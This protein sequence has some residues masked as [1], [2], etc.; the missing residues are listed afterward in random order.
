MPRTLLVVDESTTIQEAARLALTG[1][2]WHVVGA[3][4]GAEALELLRSHL[5]D[6]VLCAASLGDEDGYAV[7]RSIRS[8]AEGSS[9]PV[10]LSGAEVDEPAALKAGAAGALAKPFSSEE[11]AD[12]LRATL[13]GGLFDAEPEGVEPPGPV[14]PTHEELGGLG[15][16]FLLSPDAVA[17]PPEG[18][19]DP[20]EQVEVID[21]AEDD[22]FGD[23][24]LLDD[25]EPVAPG[26]ADVG[27]T[28]LAA[29]APESFG[30]L[31][32]G[33]PP[34]E[35]PAA[36]EPVDLDAPLAPATDTGPVEPFGAQE[37]IPLDAA[38]AEPDEG[39]PQTEIEVEP[40]PFP[41]GPTG[42]PAFAGDGWAD[43]PGPPAGPPE[44]APEPATGDAGAF[45][46]P[47]PPAAPDGAPEPE[48]PGEPPA[49]EAGF[50][51]LFEGVV[52]P[53]AGEPAGE[54][55]PEPPSPGAGDE[56]RADSPLAAPA[57]PESEP[58][59]AAPSGTDPFADL[60]AGAGREE[61]DGDRAAPEDAGPAEPP[62]FE[63]DVPAA[64]PAGEPEPPPLD[65]SWAGEAPPPAPDGGAWDEHLPA[66]EPSPAAGATVEQTVRAALERSLSAEALTP[67]VQATVERV[68]WEVVPQL[69]ERLIQEAIERLQ[70]ENP[71][72]A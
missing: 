67:V 51:S 8:T 70:N 43:A 15:D 5:P 50:D 56:L 71:P 54:P 10:I 57:Q 59:D 1:E 39:A 46:E 22:E 41:A 52:S 55:G 29:D 20:G 49:D 11:L 36:P 18:D 21:L 32:L 53:V 23:L 34:E 58:P 31:D 14:A 13:D 2:D 65:P 62:A 27:D 30:D 17:P 9:I 28:D 64:E 68:V 66:E 60:L 69:A 6:A 19:A 25:L 37:G 48:L 33:L 47:V 45:D 7:C 12:T 38:P 3:S 4:T 72:P 63:P 35:S 40:S 42:E 61:E 26:P 44:G 24:E 16:E